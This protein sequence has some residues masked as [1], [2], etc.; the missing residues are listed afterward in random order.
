MIERGYIYIAQPPLYKIK[1]GKQEQY[2]KDNEALN[3]YL[4][5]LAIEDAALFLSAAIP[6][7]SGQRPGKIGGRI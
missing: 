7:I 4:I 3:R 6:P 2:I 5:Q 1:K